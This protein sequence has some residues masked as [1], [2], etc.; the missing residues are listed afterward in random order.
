MNQTLAVQAYEYTAIV[1]CFTSVIP[2]AVP[3]LHKC[4]GVCAGQKEILGFRLWKSKLSVPVSYNS[5]RLSS[6]PTDCIKTQSC[7]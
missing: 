3:A 5:V 4:F 1:Q 7:A 6:A 2:L